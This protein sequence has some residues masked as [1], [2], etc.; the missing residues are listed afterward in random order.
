MSTQ[1]GFDARGTGA[2]TVDPDALVRR[3]AEREER[4]AKEAHEREMRA[5]SA[6]GIADTVWHTAKAAGPD[7]PYL[8]RKGVQPVDTLR[9]IAFDELAALIGHTPKRRDEPLAGRILI[10]P[11]YVDGKLST[12]EMIDGDGRKSAL[13]GG[14]KAGGYW[15]AQAMPDAPEVVLI[16][17]GVATALSASQC[18]G[19]PA[20][21]SLSV[22]QMDAAVRAM[23][24]RY[25]DAALV[26]LADLDNATGEPHPTAVKAAQALGVHLA[27]PVFDGGRQPN[28][29]DFNDMHVARGTA[30][31]KATIDAALANGTSD[32]VQRVDTSDDDAG[33]KLS[34]TP[35]PRFEVSDAGVSFV[36]V[37]YSTQ[38]D[39]RVEKARLWLS[40]RIDIVGRGED[41]AG[42]AY[43]ILR[44]RS[45]GSG[46]TRT[47]AFPL[48]S[49]AYGNCRASMKCR[50]S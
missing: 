10:A 36:G 14:A 37:E 15:T 34:G 49:I 5:R 40:D 3:R 23:R 44:W 16:A 38:A 2:A 48:S 50:S 42:R 30:Y 11:V 12:I 45:R 43:R 18:A 27:V 13:K 6:A 28:Q 39:K 47:T 7:H 26:L 22:G 24:G 32:D 4:A 21:A 1:H 25:P 29:T 9:E 33:Y 17:E 19:Y 46:G 35:R 8:M 31:V 41:D 20:I